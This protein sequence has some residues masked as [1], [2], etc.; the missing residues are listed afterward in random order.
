MLYHTVRFCP[1]PWLPIAGVAMAH[2]LH[3]PN[4]AGKEIV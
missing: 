4:E 1:L 2:N 3:L